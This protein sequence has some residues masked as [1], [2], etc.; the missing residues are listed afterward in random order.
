[1]FALDKLVSG[2]EGNRECDIESASTVVT[3]SLMLLQNSENQCERSLRVTQT[4]E[5]G[6]W[7]IYL[8]L[9]LPSVAGAALRDLVSWQSRGWHSEWHWECRDDRAHREGTH[10]ENYAPASTCLTPKEVAWTALTTSSLPL[11]FPSDSMVKNQPVMKE[12]Q[13]MWVQ[14][15]DQEDPLEE[16]MATHSSIFAWKSYEQ[17]NLVGYSPWGHKEVDTTKKAYPAAW[18][19]WTNHM[20]RNLPGWAPEWLWLL[21]PF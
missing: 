9:L 17:I 7:G 11:G 14:A 13:K 3:W 16:E 4:E 8:P 12:T 2:S 1:M 18:L 5:W 10:V 6:S 19:R 15:L 21:P 20:L